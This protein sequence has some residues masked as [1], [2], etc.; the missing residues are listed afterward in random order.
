MK[1]MDLNVVDWYSCLV[2]SI[3]YMLK[4]WLMV[5]VHMYTDK[6]WVSLCWFFCS[7]VD[8]FP[9]PGET[10]HGNKFSQGFGGKGANQCIT[11]ARLGAKVAMVAKVSFHHQYSSSSSSSSSSIFIITVINIHHHHHHHHQEHVYVVY[12]FI[13][14]FTAWYGW[15]WGKLPA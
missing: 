10:L 6:I 1:Y 3:C 12:W 9:K 2:I 13:T 14:T 15:I 5:P 8:R 7:Y 11:A 4:G